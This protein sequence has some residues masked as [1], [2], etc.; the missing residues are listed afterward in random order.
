M[1]IFKIIRI[2]IS[3]IVLILFLSCFLFAGDFFDS[4]LSSIASWQFFPAIIKL[5]KNETVTAAIILIPIITLLF[6]RIYCSTVCPLGTLQDCTSFLNRKKK[7]SY[8]NQNIFIRY[9]VPLIA[10]IFFFLSVSL[11][12]TLIEPYTI[13]SRAENCFLLPMGYRISIETADFI[14]YLSG[15]ILILIL[16][17]SFFKGRLYCN[18]ICP[19]G[20][21]LSLFTRF[22]IF[23]IKIN[24]NK[25]TSCGKCE[26]ACKAECIE[27]KNKAID[28]SKCVMCFNCLSACKPTALRYS[29][30]GFENEKEGKSDRHS[31]HTRRSFLSLGAV[32]VLSYPASKLFPKKSLTKIPVT[33]PGS[34]GL[35]HF[36]ESCTACQLCVT[37]CP[38]GVLRPS[39]F[40]YGITGI[41]QPYL[42]FNCNSCDYNCIVCLKACPSGAIAPLPLHDKRMISLGNAKIDKEICIVYKNGTACAAC[43]E[44]CPTGATH[45]INYKNG[46]PAP[47]VN[48][49]MCIGCGACEYAC[50]TK[51][52][53]AIIV[54]PFAEHQKIKALPTKG[55][56]VTTD[57]DKEFAF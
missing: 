52:K 2:V 28:N 18:S 9:T 48:T 23:R 24:K 55:R 38:T 11:I 34:T 13:V 1:K 3:G 43:D 47:T 50:P 7:Y 12:I 19:V 49:D 31:S 35:K 25:C 36:T 22:S 44:M 40:E 14:L 53:K 37:Q 57:K 39:L 17:L 21:V 5:I 46:L 29:V 32:G 8:R 45:M 10:I 51:P 26:N 4:L 33:P 41:M 54:E 16:I 15:T 27:L 56:A 6:G 30:N 42:D 20:A